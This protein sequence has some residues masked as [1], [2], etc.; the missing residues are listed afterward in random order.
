MNNKKG[1]TLVELI[2]VIAVL[3]IILIIALPQ[4][5]R[6]QERNKKKKYETYQE[7][8]ESAAKLYMDNNVRDI[9]AHI[10]FNTYD[11]ANSWS[12]VVYGRATWNYS[13]VSRAGLSG[14]C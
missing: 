11:H 8:L 5:Q 10:Y 13:N 12:E 6:I 1:F 7:S 2:V 4:V 9:V 3:G 14:N